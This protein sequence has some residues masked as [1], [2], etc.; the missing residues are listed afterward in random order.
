MDMEI[1][2]GHFCHI[3]FYYFR[4]GNNAMQ[5]RKK[6][7][8]VYG[9][10]SLTE[11]QYQKWFARF[12]SGDFDL[13][14]VPR[15]RRPIEVDEDKIKAMMENNQRSTTQEIAEKLNISHTCV[16]SRVTIRP[17]FPEH[18]LFLGLV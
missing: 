1:P 2:D 13:K 6:L 4:K 15:S 11:R 9:E 10:E 5:A 8:G 17:D 12:H 14:D 18:G 16:E 3:L 7:Y